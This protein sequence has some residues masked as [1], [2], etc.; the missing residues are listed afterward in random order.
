MVYSQEELQRIIRSLLSRYRAES[1]ILFGSYARREAHAASDID[2]V[3]IGGAD[4]DPTDVFSFADD[5]FNITGKNVDVFELREI[6]KDTP[7]YHAVMEEG[8]RIA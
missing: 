7:F 2:L 5:L 8:V 1:G 3:I 6:E 4:F